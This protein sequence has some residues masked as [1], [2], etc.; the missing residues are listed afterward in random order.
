M[1]RN[2]ESSRMLSSDNSNEDTLVD[3]A[4]MGNK[5]SEKRIGYEDVPQ[6]PL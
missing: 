6:Y 1:V 4:G 5:D 3:L 2:N